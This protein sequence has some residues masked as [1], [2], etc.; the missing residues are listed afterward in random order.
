MQIAKTMNALYR[1]TALGMALL[2]LGQ[3]VM[4]KLC[5]VPRN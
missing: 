1:T 5:V 3:D 4:L 2:S